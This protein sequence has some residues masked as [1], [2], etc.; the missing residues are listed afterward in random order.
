MQMSIAG[1]TNPASS[2]FKL[3][4][5]MRQTQS[6]ALTDLSAVVTAAAPAKHSTKSLSTLV[7]Q[8]RRSQQFQR[9]T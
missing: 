5:Y 1:P 6:E 7:T 2:A 3:A 4:T 9:T 8:M